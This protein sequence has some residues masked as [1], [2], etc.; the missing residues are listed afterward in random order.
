MSRTHAQEFTIKTR[1]LI[2][3]D[4]ATQSAQNVR[5][6]L[7]VAVSRLAGTHGL[8]GY[9]V[10]LG[11]SSKQITLDHEAAQAQLSLF[12]AVA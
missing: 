11:G 10:E 6:A 12:A 8:I 7:D 9:D 3:D 5:E 1:V 4:D 2:V